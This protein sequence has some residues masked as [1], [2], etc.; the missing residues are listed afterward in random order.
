MQNST[1]RLIPKS[2]V[3]PQTSAQTAV[4]LCWTR[5]ELA[6]ASGLSYRTIV[7]L[8]A[9]GLLRRV[10]LGVKVVLYTDESVRALLGAPVAVDKNKTLNV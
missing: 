5:R 4:K 6:R 7:N 8:E 10:A 1:T 2:A 9:R 3:E